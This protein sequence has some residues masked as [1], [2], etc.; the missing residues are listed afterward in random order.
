MLLDATAV[1]CASTG[2]IKM[3][4][5]ALVCQAKSA[6]GEDLALLAT[7]GS[8]QAL[9]PNQRFTPLLH[10]MCGLL[11]LGAF[12]ITVQFAAQSLFTDPELQELTLLSNC[13]D[14]VGCLGRTCN[15]GAIRGCT[16]QAQAFCPLEGRC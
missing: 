7:R 11:L 8:R 2:H 15:A 9:F 12:P 5:K 4:L 14:I 16:K 13:G 6:R 3:L 1:Q 10:V